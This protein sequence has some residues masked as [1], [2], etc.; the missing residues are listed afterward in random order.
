MADT[1][2]SVGD[3]DGKIDGEDRGKQDGAQK[4]TTSVAN[5]AIGFTNGSRK[6]AAGTTGRGT[7]KIN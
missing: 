1:D 6:K 3:V 7:R 4:A 5:E 2:L